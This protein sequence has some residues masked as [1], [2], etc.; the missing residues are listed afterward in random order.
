MG[1]LRKVLKE[2]LKDWFQLGPVSVEYEDRTFLTFHFTSKMDSFTDLRCRIWVQ[3]EDDT[4]YSASFT[5]YTI[6][7]ATK[8]HDTVEPFVK[9]A[10]IKRWRIVLEYA[11]EVASM[12]E[13]EPAGPAGWWEGESE[14]LTYWGSDPDEDFGGAKK[15]AKGTKSAKQQKISDAYF[16]RTLGK[17][18]ADRPAGGKRADEKDDKEEE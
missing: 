8:H 16:S 14:A 7:K 2:K 10:R 1:S 9:K 13:S 11:D 12:K 5:Y 6:Q 15:D 3:L 4:L 17:K 18:T